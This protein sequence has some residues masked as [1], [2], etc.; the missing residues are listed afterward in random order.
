MVENRIEK[1]FI[2]DFIY[3]NDD[4]RYIEDILISFHRKYDKLTNDE[5]D[6]IVINDL[7]NKV[8]KNFYK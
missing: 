4:L 2:S 7:W 5:K 3:D 1:K 8:L 6:T